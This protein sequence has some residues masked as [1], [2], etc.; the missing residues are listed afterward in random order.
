MAN[1]KGNPQ[2]LLRGR[3]KGD[4]APTSKEIRLTIYEALSKFD[5]AKIAG[6]LGKLPPREFLATYT[7]LAKLILPPPQPEPDETPQEQTIILKIGN[8]ENNTD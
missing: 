1:P 2:N 6:Y 7:N 5:S 4:I 8:A 3:R